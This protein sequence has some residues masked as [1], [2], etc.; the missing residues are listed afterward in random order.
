MNKN[1][2]RILIILTGLVTALIH[3]FL[4]VTSLGDSLGIPFILNGLIYLALVYAVVGAPG[5]LQGRERLAHYLLIG[6]AAVTFVLYFVFNG[7]EG[8]TGP[9]GMISKIDEVLL[10]IFTFLHLRAVE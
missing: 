2:L 10:I 4:G 6:F 5:F 1:V 9:I 7:A 3:I 8:L